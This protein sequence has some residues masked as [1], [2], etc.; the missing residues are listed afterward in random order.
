M[1]LMEDY[2]G[3]KIRY[4]LTPDGYTVGIIVG[5]RVEVVDYGVA[6]IEEAERIARA[7]VD[8]ECDV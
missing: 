2:K 3:Y 5:D 6:T 7:Y 8:K 4:H 1:F